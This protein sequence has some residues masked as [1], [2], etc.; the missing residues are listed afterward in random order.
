M[1]RIA[2]LFIL[3]V[4]ILVSCGKAEPKTN[5]KTDISVDSISS[6]II[7][8][9]KDVLLTEADENYVAL[10]VPIET[11]LA[12]DFVIYISTTANANLIGVFKAASE[13]NAEKLLTQSKEY[14]QTLEDNWMSDYLPEELP[15]IQN[16]VC[17]KFGIYVTFIVLD[18][19]PRD[20]AI[21][22][23]EN[24]LKK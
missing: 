12:E 22:D 9:A 21:K 20:N 16:A 3:C 6:K 14:L 2:I 1:K 23:V 15:K 24:M 13:E 11:S 8:N 10:N 5:Y 4:F 19:A 18:D 17:Q 7:E